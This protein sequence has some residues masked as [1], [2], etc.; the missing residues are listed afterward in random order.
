MI[1]WGEKKRIFLVYKI[2][3]RMIKTL[4]I[5]VLNAHRDK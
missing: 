4:T 1:R 5:V 2:M 3:I